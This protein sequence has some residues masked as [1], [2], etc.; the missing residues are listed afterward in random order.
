MSEAS[1]FAK[2][3]S[4][5]FD[6]HVNVASTQRVFLAALKTSPAYRDLLQYLQR[7]PDAAQEI[8][9]RV[10]D[11]VTLQFDPRYA[12]PNDA[13]IA[14]YLWALAQTQPEFGRITA[15]V[16]LSARQTWWARTVALLV[17][18]NAGAAARVEASPERAT[19]NVAFVSN[20]QMGSVPGVDRVHHQEVLSTLLTGPIK[21]ITAY[22]VTVNREVTVREASPAAWTWARQLSLSMPAAMIRRW[23][24]GVSAEQTVAAGWN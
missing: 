10:K 11:L 14:A 15:E 5:E 22:Q 8:F 7:N 16:V 21:I 23:V 24:R 9:S 17:L 3:E 19:S 12:N 13:A 2:I 18:D 4:P 1:L 20:L 6:A